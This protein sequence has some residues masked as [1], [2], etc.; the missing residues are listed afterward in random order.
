LFFI[1]YLA[2]VENSNE[3]KKCFQLFFEEDAGSHLSS[4]VPQ[5]VWLIPPVSRPT[6]KAQEYWTFSC[7]CF[8]DF[9][10]AGQ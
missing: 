6:K 7:E 9:T 10:S 4:E 3:R 5:T 8:S 1:G 2:N